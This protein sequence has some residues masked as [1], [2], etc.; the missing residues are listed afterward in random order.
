MVKKIPLT[1]G[2]YA[3]VNDEYFEFLNQWKWHAANHKRLRGYYAKSSQST[4]G[5]GCKRKSVMMHRLIMENALG[6]N[7]NQGEVIDHM[8]HD[9]LDNRRENLRIVSTRQNMQNLK[10]KTTSKYPGV[11]WNKQKNKWLA[12][13]MVNGKNKHLGLFIDEREAAKAYER[14]CRELAGEELV[15]KTKGVV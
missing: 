7:L 14:A 2:Q 9:T 10:R 3:L 13:I 15:C 12:H 6:R 11:Y 8:N 5:T 1:Q 4:N